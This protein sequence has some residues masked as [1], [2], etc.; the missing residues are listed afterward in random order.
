MS[1]K[2]QA[3][4]YLLVLLILAGLACVFVRPMVRRP[5]TYV[6]GH[7]GEAIFNIYILA[8]TYHA[9]G[10]KPLNLYNTTMFFPNSTWQVQACSPWVNP[11]TRD[12]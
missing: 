3:L 5:G 2:R 8:W 7:T 11:A 6:L 9:L 12:D 1:R 10:T 4:V